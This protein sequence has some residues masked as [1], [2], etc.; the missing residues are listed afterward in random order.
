MHDWC[1][2]GEI[3]DDLVS[4]Y[5]SRDSDRHQRQLVVVYE[6]NYIFEGVAAVGP[7]LDRGSRQAFAVRAQV[8]A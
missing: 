2:A 6:L 3:E 1:G 4:S 7:F 5:G 8:A